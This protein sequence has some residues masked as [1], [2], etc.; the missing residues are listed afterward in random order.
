[1][2]T[3]AKKL[4]FWTLLMVSTYTFAQTNITINPSVSYQTID[5]IGGGIVYYLDWLTTHK[6]KTELYDTIYT[7]LGLSAL[8]I[9]N[10]AQEENADLTYDAEIV[11]EAKKR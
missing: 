2:K 7:G 11:N 6:N 1:M 3:V 8:R 5:G 9:G 4:S 10:W